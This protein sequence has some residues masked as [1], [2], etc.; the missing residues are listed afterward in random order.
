MKKRLIALLLLL[1]ICAEAGNAKIDALVKT[2]DGSSLW[3]GSSFY[4]VI[5]LPSGASITQVLDRLQTT[6][7][8]RFTSY[9]IIAS[10]TASMV[11]DHVPVRADGTT[12]RTPVKEP[13]SV[14][15]I[16]TDVGEKIVF[17]H[18][19]KESGWRTTIYDTK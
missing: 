19:S 3:G 14:V 8:A 5:E 1:P 4:P 10:E 18:Y 9:K 17:M 12:V 13:I 7:F 11:L 6:G 2:F 15:L 16:K